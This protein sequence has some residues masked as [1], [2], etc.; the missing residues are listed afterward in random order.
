MSPPQKSI[1]P[2]A[3]SRD[4][5]FFQFLSKHMIM[6]ITYHTISKQYLFH[7]SN[8]NKVL[9]AC[10]LSRS[11]SSIQTQPISPSATI[12]TV[13]AVLN[14]YQI[15]LIFT[16]SPHKQ[17]SQPLHDIFGHISSKSCLFQLLRQVSHS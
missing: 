17:V 15:S 9:S 2:L 16:Y 13:T 6:M 12:T 10:V 5:S 7:V 3:V 1:H 4:M 14:P 11:S 8:Q